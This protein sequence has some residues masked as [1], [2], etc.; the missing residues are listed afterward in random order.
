MKKITVMS[1]ALTPQSVGSFQTIVA[2]L[3][4]RGFEINH[5]GVT[6]SST[7]KNVRKATGAAYQKFLKNVYVL[8]DIDDHNFV[9][10]V[11]KIIARHKPDVFLTDNERIISVFL[12]NYLQEKMV[13][14]VMVDH[15]Y[16]SKPPLIYM[17]PF[18]RMFKHQFDMLRNYRIR[19]NRHLDLKQKVKLL[20]SN[21]SGTK[22]DYLICAGN[23]LNKNNYLKFGVPEKRITLTGF[24]Y[25]D[26]VV[27]YKKSLPPPHSLI[28]A[29]R[30]KIL[31]ISSGIGMITGKRKDAETF[32][33]FVINAAC[34]L[35]RDFDLTMRFK[36]GENI[37]S[38]LSPLTSQKL[39]SAHLMFDN[40]QDKSYQAVAS[41]DL[42]MGDASF[43]LLEALIFHKPVIVFRYHSSSLYDYHLDYFFKTR[44]GMLI[45]D[46]PPQVQEY[47]VTAFSKG[48]QHLLKENLKKNESDFFTKLDGHAGERVADVIQKTLIND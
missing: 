5:I 37:F 44:S 17:N 42:V 27:S 43:V 36:P 47:V 6:E 32:A 3:E 7:M 23:M 28:P 20:M 22:G 10:N 26:N 18:C 34:L 40:L 31:I 4:R 8:P 29:R 9:P 25:F 35:S 19:N 39:K 41:H 15:G 48:Y 30:K 46:N 16:L 13:P 11:E 14:S 2:N 38:M 33:D 45:L 12:I 24:S 1:H 21:P